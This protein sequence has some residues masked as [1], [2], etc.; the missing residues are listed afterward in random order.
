M[1]QIILAILIFVFGISGYAN[2]PL[3]RNFQRET[4]KAGTQNWSIVQDNQNS[5]YFANNN[6][7]LIFDGEKW[8]TVPIKN[9]TNVRSL[10][11]TKDGRFYASTFN[12]FGYFKKQ[13]NQFFY[14]S[15]SEKLNINK[16]ESNALFSIIDGN[17]VIYFQGEKNIYEYSGSKIENILFY[18]KIDASA[19]IN[20]VLFLTSEQSGAFILNGKHFLR[21][22]G[23]EILINKKVCSI[24]A[25][26]SENILFVTN[27]NGVYLFNG[28]TFIYYNTGIDKFL[29]ENQVFCAAKKN[30]KLVFGTVQRGLAILDLSDKTTTYVNTFNGLQN[31]TILS[32]AFDNQMNLWLG[33]DKGI[34][35]VILNTPI[36]SVLGRNNLY[37]SGYSSFL[38][39]NTLYL[40][41]NQGLNTCSYPLTK[42]STPLPLKL[43]K[44]MEG[45]V[46]SLTEIENTLFCGNDHGAYVISSDRV[47]KIQGLK[48]TWGFRQLK[49]HPDIILGCSYQGLFY[50][51]KISNNWKLMGFVKGRFTE[52]S[53]MFEEDA[54][55][56]VWFSHWQKGLYHLYFNA[57]MDSIT[58]GDIYNQKN[59]FPS[60]RNNTLFC[61]GNNIIFSTQYGF[62]QFN[63]RTRKM[64]FSTK[65]N[66]LFNTIPSDMRLHETKNGDVWCV[67]GRFIGLAKK[68]TDNTYT[69]DSLSYRILQSKLIIGFENFYSIDANNQIIGTEEGFS[70]INTQS[71]LTQKYT[72]KVFVRNIY[73]TNSNS[74][75]IL[76]NLHSEEYKPQKEYSHK[77]NSLLFE[78]IASEYRTDDAIQYS[79]MLENYD[80]T[81]SAYTSSNTKEYTKL[82][83]G[84]YVFKIRAHNMLDSKESFCSYAFSILPAWYETKLAYT[85]YFILLIIFITLLVITINL[86]SK[87][88][89]LKME[90][91]KEIQIQERQI[92]FEKETSVKKKEFTE[93]KNQQLQYELRHKS[94]E[95]ANSTMNLIRKNEIMM[96][97]MDHITKVSED[98]KKNGDINAILSRFSKMEQNIIQNIENDDNLKKFEE[99]FDL[100][101]ENYLKRLGEMYPELNVSDKKICAYLKM[102]LSSKDIAP[103]L[104]MSIRSVE[105]NRYRLRKKLQLE[106][107]VNL[108]DFL[109]RL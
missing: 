46:W 85:L 22:P 93:L 65:W 101:Y 14:H 51:K 3:V 34:D 100:I 107:D 15:L 105:T 68:K 6:G 108:S 13:N 21:L 38:K 89:A 72:F 81:W 64:E 104:N 79:Y 10:L 62:F 41:T 4:Y 90:K 36:Q 58:R 30:N 102:D 24:L 57:A 82:P 98:I 91:I 63:N 26:D 70:W 92:L 55:G 12:D 75:T 39:N 66:K 59:G 16:Q 78:F 83:K 80:K 54:D 37:G 109:Q 103:L 69:M 52:S 88:G 18:N 96:E 60:N 61:V 42:Y 56:T 43:M 86:Q 44:G 33:L 53:P 77:E 95:L 27:F 73:V 17:K 49:K 84:D 9:R 97:I 47:E 19:Y 23:S 48:G 28:I 32:M 2:Y 1:K 76:S 74:Q 20:N 99:N 71:K 106:R 94:Q 45:Q 11:Y 29:K 5:M 25:L 50:M 40:G 67:S 87:K 7:L 8:T 31:N 35:Y